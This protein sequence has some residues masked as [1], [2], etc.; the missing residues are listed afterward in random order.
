MHQPKKSLVLAI[1]V[2]WALIFAGFIT[3][4]ELNLRSGREIIL[5]TE[6]VDPR[7][8]FRGDYVI[9][10]YEISR[11]DSSQANFADFEVGDS[12]YANLE[13]SGQD[14]NFSALSRSPAINPNLISLK[15]TV[16]RK[17]NNDIDIDYGIESYFVPE[18]RGREIENTIREEEVKVKIAVDQNGQGIIKELLI[19][20]E[21]IGF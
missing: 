9:L 3:N 5:K 6:P 7:D 14:W 4:R 21:P 15:G 8:L 10:N 2:L 11:I 17:D 20:N 16:T 12:I 1:I 19:N 18:G 13:Q